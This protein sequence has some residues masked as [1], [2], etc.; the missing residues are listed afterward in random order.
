MALQYHPIEG[1]RESEGDLWPWVARYAHGEDYHLL[2]GDGLRRLAGRIESAY[3]GS[4][5]RPYVDTGPIL[6]RELAA[7]AGL[8]AIGKNTNLLHP[9]AGSWFL[10]GELLLT[11]DLESDIPYEDLCGSCTACL[12]AC[13]TGA[14]P[15]P[16]RL[17]SRRCISYWTIEHRGVVPEEMRREMGNWVFGCDICQQVCPVNESP[18]S[19]SEQRL[20]LPSARQEVTLESLLGMSRDEYVE[21]FRRSPMKRAKLEGLKR[22]AAVAMGNRGS[23]TYIPA[24][25]L[26]VHEDEEAVVRSH[27]AWALGRIGGS[28]ARRALLEALESEADEEVR[29]SLSAALEALEEAEDS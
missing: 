29:T 9:E 22:N 11:L 6:E 27:A 18:L 24:L 10:L 2:M 7:R 3:P 26:A 23:E 8:G 1:G 15:E 28:T 20:R 17:D 12:E 19:G 21:R 14:L 4:S 5:T 13:P 25:Q 16:F